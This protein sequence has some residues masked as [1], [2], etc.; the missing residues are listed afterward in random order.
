MSTRILSHCVRVVGLLLLPTVAWAQTTYYVNG[1][2]GDNAWTGISSVCAAPDGPKA[3]IQA[4]INATS[5]GDVVFVADGVY[6][7]SGNKNLDYNGRL[8]TVRSAN[9][10]DTC[11]IDLQRSGRAFGFDSGETTDS[12]I[13]GFTITNGSAEFG[14]GFFSENA[15]ASVVDCMFISNSAEIVGG[16]IYHSE[17][18]DLILDNCTFIANVGT[19]SVGGVFSVSNNVILSDCVFL[20]NVGGLSIGGLAVGFGEASLTNCS[21]FQ[22]DGVFVGGG[23]LNGGD[24]TLV[25]CAFSGNT[26]T[27]GGGF[28]NGLIATLI[29]CTFGNNAGNGVENDHGVSAVLANCVL[30]GNVP[31]QLDL[32]SFTVTYS[33][34][35][36][37]WPGTGNID[38]DPLFAQPGADNLRL[39]FGSPC[40]D[41][42]DNDA[43][44]DGITTDLD[45][46]PRFVDD[47]DVDDTGNGTPPIVDMGAYEGG[48]PF[49]DPTAV[50]D[51]LDQNETVIL[52]PNGGSFDPF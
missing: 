28:Q 47:P 6:T 18:G 36:G 12:V 52:I 31:A 25:N 48:N 1:S 45:G 5:N 42:G 49:S 44:P 4:A 50:E 22:N 10:P 24:I 40:I 21:F 38:A 9:G 26:A 3:T 8:I 34:I 11:I 17:E 27:M 2:C 32:G 19:N 13:Q 51:D 37:G 39:G 29:N 43:V 16:A 33:D 35:Q 41:A 7:G 46:L 23:I 14:G 15:G 30:W 20:G